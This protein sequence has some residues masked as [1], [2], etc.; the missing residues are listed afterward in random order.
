MVRFAQRPPLAVALAIVAVFAVYHGHAHGA[1]LPGSANPIADTLGFVVA[2]G[3]LHL[4]GIAIGFLTTRP[5]G[6]LTRARR[7]RCH[8]AGRGRVP[9][10]SRMILPVAALLLLLLV[11]PAAAHGALPGGAGFQAGALHPI[12]ALDHLLAL[13][14]TGLALGRAKGGRRGLVATGLLALVAGLT[15]G[16]TRGT[17]PAPSPGV[18]LLVALVPGLLLLWGH[19]LPVGMVAPPVLLLGWAIGA[20]TDIG[21]A[22]AG[23]GLIVAAGLIV[24]NMAALLQS[25]GARWPILPRIAGSWFFVMSLMVLALRIGTGSGLAADLP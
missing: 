13:L 22:V 8:R 15:L 25:A 11:G 14:V 5:A 12:V 19:P 6:T 7:R 10:G 9:D 3:L 20:D 16:L 1:E 21:A 23:A 4:C 18:I 2:T 24:L 17:V